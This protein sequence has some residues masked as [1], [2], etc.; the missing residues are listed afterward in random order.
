MVFPRKT[1][2]K[3]SNKLNVCSRTNVQKSLRAL[4]FDIIAILT[5]FITYNP[6][7]KKTK[8][9]ALP[10][11]GSG[12]AIKTQ[13]RLSLVVPESV[14]HWDSN[15]RVFRSL[16][17]DRDGQ[18]VSL[19]LPKFFT[20]KQEPSDQ[21]SLDLALATGEK[22]EWTIKSDG[23]LCIRSVIGERVVFRTRNS[24]DGENYGDRMKAVAEERYP[25]LLDPLFCKDL[26][27]HFEFVSSK[28]RVVIEYAEDDLLL[29]GGADHKTLKLLS[30]QD[31]LKMT[32]PT[33]LAELLASNPLKATPLINENFASVKE[34]Q[35]WVEWQD[36][37]EGL[38]ARWNSSQSL[39]KI[40]HSAYE[41]AHSARFTFNAKKVWAIYSAKWIDDPER[42]LRALKPKTE[43]ATAR[44]LA[45]HKKCQQLREQIDQTLVELEQTAK[46]NQTLSKKE[47]AALAH[48]LEVPRSVALLAIKDGKTKQA[49]ELLTN[50]WAKEW[51]GS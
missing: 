38:V 20:A 37:I 17:F 5:D 19:G 44:L 12:F 24:F 50:Q 35:A 30:S 8:K 49:R 10:G 16:I 1:L 34:A 40:K 14:K 32:Q 46:A 42:F 2:Q 4:E 36:N 26:S 47:F 39:L 3:N 29:V 18:V 9:L 6:K 15:S 22:A 41:E 31:V 28:T 48:D 27:L 13:G 51:F 33:S 23:A 11:K 25:V 21:E 43:S 7:P 45:L